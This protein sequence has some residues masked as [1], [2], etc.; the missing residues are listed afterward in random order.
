MK[1]PMVSVPSVQG[2]IWAWFHMQTAELMQSPY[3]VQGGP[4]FPFCGSLQGH[5]PSYPGWN[6]TLADGTGPHREGVT[7]SCLGEQHPAAPPPPLDRGCL[8]EEGASSGRPQP[9]ATL[10]DYIVSVIDSVSVRV[11]EEALQEGVCRSV[12]PGQNPPRPSETAPESSASS[13]FQDP[14]AWGHRPKAGGVGQASRASSGALNEPAVSQDSG[15]CVS[16]E[17]G[18]G[19]EVDSGIFTLSALACSSPGLSPVK[20][21]PFSPSQ[22]AESQQWLR[23]GSE[24]TD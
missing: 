10:P 24:L 4:E 15:G 18:G 16:P 23:T 22:V 13:I 2:N 8:P 7:T 6:R 9:M 14:R 5:M 12:T 1:N 21:L 19:D 11:A 17:G 20:H 3:L